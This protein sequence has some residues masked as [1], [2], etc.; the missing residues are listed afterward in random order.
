MPSLR[1]ALVFAV[2]SCVAALSGGTGAGKGGCVVSSAGAGRWYRYGPLWRPGNAPGAVG[3]DFSAAAACGMVKGYG[4]ATSPSPRARGT[5]NT[6][7]RFGFGSQKEFVAVAMLQL[8]SQGKLAITDPVARWL[9]RPSRVPEPITV[10]DLLGP[11]GG[12]YRDYYPLDYVDVGKCRSPIT[13]GGDRRAYGSFPLHRPRPR[14]RLGVQQTRT[15]AHRRRI[16]SARRAHPCR[17]HE[18]ETFSILRKLLRTAFDEPPAGR[19]RIGRS[20]YIRFS[21]S[22]RMRN[23][24]EAPAAER[25]RSVGQERRAISCVSDAGAHATPSFLG[26]IVIQPP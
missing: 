20:G 18:S 2:L 3:R 25:C 19:P 21:A 16:W 13:G 8:A 24:F 1:A 9:S 5:R 4:S 23:P 10:A 26:R 11:S 15:S 12:P 6:I 7:F 17:R 14:T 22:R